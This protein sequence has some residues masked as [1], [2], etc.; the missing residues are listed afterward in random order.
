[1]R[2]TLTDIR[3][4]LQREEYQNEEHVRLSLVCRL[5][6]KLGWNIW[7]AKEVNTEFQPIPSEDK[8]RV[9]IALFA[10]RLLPSIFIEA[11]AVGKIDPNLTDI[12]RQ[13]RDYNRNNTALFS[14]ITDGRMWRFYYSQTGGEFPHKCFKKCDL[15]EGDI[16]D[17]EKTLF[18]FFGKDNI[19]NGYAEEQAKIY[20]QL[21]T[22]QRAIQDCLLHAKRLVQLPP[23]PSLPQAIVNLL[24]QKGISILEEEVSEL[25]RRMPEQPIPETIHPQDFHHSAGVV[26][27][28]SVTHRASSGAIP[29]NVDNPGDLH[30][31]KVEGTIDGEY[32]RKWKDLV[33]IGIRRAVRSGDNVRSLNADLPAKIREGIYTNEGYS[34][35]EDLNLSVQGMD[36]NNAAKTLVMLAKKL[37]CQLELIVSW[38][39]K[40]SRTG[41][42]GVIRWP[43]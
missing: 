8:T 7:D 36:A 9:D 11:K 35:I 18:L 40:S 10:N 23:Y 12:E 15:L 34:P 30:F 39:G 42:Q 25:L 33:A 16:E 5:L 43:S 17:I 19:L 31:T 38:Y 3:E 37:N 13:V 24:K 20:L 29:L 2:E 41:K 32:G 14:V 27:N 26:S 28:Q 6:Y 22:K 4:K 21:T 1:M